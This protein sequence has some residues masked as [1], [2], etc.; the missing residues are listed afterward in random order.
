MVKTTSYLLKI[1]L[2]CYIYIYTHLLR[3]NKAKNLEFRMIGK[4]WECIASTVLHTFQLHCIVFPMNIENKNIFN[5]VMLLLC[6]QVSL[7]SFACKINYNHI[8]PN[9][10]RHVMA[11]FVRYGGLLVQCYLI[12][13]NTIKHIRAMIW[14][15]RF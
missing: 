9:I 15:L 4:L 7:N 8:S 2:K 11:Y 3:L 13:R 14:V 5:V 12:L 1:F 6:K 10:W